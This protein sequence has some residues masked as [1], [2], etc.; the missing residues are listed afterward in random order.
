MEE[1]EPIETIAPSS[2]DLVNVQS[3][4]DT[5]DSSIKVYRTY[6]RRFYILALFS[7]HSMMQATTWNTWGPVAHT[8][9]VIFGWGD[10]T[11]SLL[12][13]WGPIL[14]ILTFIPMVKIL[15][16]FGLRFAV[17]HCAF[18]IMVACIVRSIPG[19]TLFRTM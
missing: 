16:R 19:S 14:F 8:A 15:L 1:E 17:V 6:Y 2:Q 13:A 4:E 11:L 9:Y 10:T 5:S 3:L 7:V 12:P 18:L